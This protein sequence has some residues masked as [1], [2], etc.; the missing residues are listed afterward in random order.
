MCRLCATLERFLP[1][2]QAIQARN[3]SDSPDQMNLFV[4]YS[5]DCQVCAQFNRVILFGD[6]GPPV[7]FLS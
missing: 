7:H 3:A 4:L 1:V 5:G 2:G 6:R